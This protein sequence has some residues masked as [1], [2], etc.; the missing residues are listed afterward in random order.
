MK[1]SI[2]V[3]SLLLIASASGCGGGAWGIKTPLDGDEFKVQSKLYVVGARKG[4]ADC[5][6]IAPPDWGGHPS[7][8]EEDIKEYETGDDTQ[9]KY[10]AWKIYGTLE[11]GDRI[12]VARSDRV[13]ST[14]FSGYLSKAEIL[15]GPF[16]GEQ[17]TL[18]GLV[19]SGQTGK[20]VEEWNP[21]EDPLPSP[22]QWRLDPRYLQKIKEAEK[23]AETPD[24]PAPAHVTP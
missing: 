9:A 3:L 11:P 6:F 10:G 1:C 17:L 4:G 22:E 23:P 5:W 16:K 13:S 21:Y 20:P 2:Y 8:I 24:A 14:S 18:H 15:T 12:R 7:M 19:L